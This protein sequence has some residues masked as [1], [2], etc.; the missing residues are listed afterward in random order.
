ML[1]QQIAITPRAPLLRG[2]L[3]SALS[4]L[5]GWLTLNAV[6]FT[7]A[8]GTVN[9]PPRP[10]DFADTLSWS[11]ALVGI[12]WLL[13]LLPLYLLIPSRSLLWRWYICA[14]CGA[15]AGVLIYIVLWISST[16]Y[17]GLGFVIALAAIIGGAV[18]FFT[19]L[20]LRYF[21]FAKLPRKYPKTAWRWVFLFSQTAL[22]T[23]II[24]DEVQLSRG[25]RYLDFQNYPIRAEIVEYTLI[26]TTA[27]LLF[28][29]PYFFRRLG[30]IAISGWM[31]AIVHLAWG[32]SL[33][34][35]GNGAPLWP[36]T[37]L[38]AA[39]LDGM[40]LVSV[41]PLR[42]DLRIAVGALRINAKTNSGSSLRSPEVTTPTPAAPSLPSIHYNGDPG[43]A[44]L[45]DEATELHIWAERASE[46]AF[47]M[48]RGDV[49]RIL[50][51]YEYFE[52][53]DEH[54]E[55]SGG[56][57]SIGHLNPSDNRYWIP[58]KRNGG[59]IRVSYRI[60]EH[61]LMGIE[62]DYT[63]IS[64]NASGKSSGSAGSPEDRVIGLPTLY[65]LGDGG[66]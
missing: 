35:R 15:A 18:C 55:L 12:L 37:S 16:P 31:L 1:P 2:I 26:G 3:G 22:V 64:R 39:D 7:L 19:S 59:G 56:R 40:P 4:A 33:A 9:E 52:G 65:Y 11:A 6:M 23:L 46:I 17:L 34:P 50:N 32:L 63:G 25:Y 58:T 8:F 53:S 45:A 30:F 47:G 5:A 20:T 62:Y 48:R 57:F 51:P 43:H 36:V 28:V 54:L 66:Y 49:E 42:D 10:I 14:S 44:L 60:T 41:P 61:I 21:R 27:F 24:I 29:S 38:P 13:G